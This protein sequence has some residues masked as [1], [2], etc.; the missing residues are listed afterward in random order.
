[1]PLLS[2]LSRDL[3]LGTWFGSTCNVILANSIIT[4][5]VGVTAAHTSA[6]QQV[7]NSTALLWLSK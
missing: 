4:K 7:S 1:M 5:D 3:N 2:R 6:G